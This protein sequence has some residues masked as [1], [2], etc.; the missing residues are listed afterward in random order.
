MAGRI[1]TALG[2][3][4]SEKL[5][6][7]VD[8]LFLSETR[9]T[10]SIENEIPDNNRAASFRRLLEQA[11]EPV[12]LTEMQLARYAAILISHS[13]PRTELLD[14]V[15]DSASSNIWLKSP[16]PLWLYAYFDATV[17][18][19]GRWLD[20]RQSQLNTR[21]NV[22]VE[23]RGKLSNNKR[24]LLEGRDDKQVGVNP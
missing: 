19:L 7:A 10:Y 22:I 18:E 5:A 12:R 17:S 23:G 16:Q 6:R 13:R 3:L 1:V 2:N 21:I 8:C 14:C 9:S 11:G 24:K 15:L 4:D 20:M